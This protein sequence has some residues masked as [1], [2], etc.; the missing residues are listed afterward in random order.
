MSSTLAHTRLSNLAF[1]WRR[2][3][4]DIARN[5]DERRL[6]FAMRHEVF[7]DELLAR[8]NGDGLESDGFDTACDHLLIRDA[9]SGD[10]VGTSRLACSLWAGRSYSGGEFELGGLPALPGVKVEVG[11]TCLRRTYRNNLSVVALGHGI[12]AYARAVGAR[13]LFGCSSIPLAAPKRIAALAAR[14]AADGL[15]KGSCGV[16]PR[17]AW[18]DVEVSE[19]LRSGVA[20]ASDADY[21]AMVP[22]LLRIYLRAGSAVS[23]EPAIDRDFGCYDF[24]TLLD[25]RA[26]NSTFLQRFG[27]T[28]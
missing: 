19:A 28:W 5:A 4:I 3:T 1:T 15:T 6:C 22:P 12:G 10:P 26:H 18:R 17:T 23:A 11:R 8:P 14:F 21:E 9:I 16:T 27:P 25:L 24:F 2:F 20:V 7:L 13:W